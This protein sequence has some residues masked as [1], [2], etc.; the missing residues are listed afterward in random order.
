MAPQTLDARKNGST[1]AQVILYFVQ[2]N[3]LHWIDNNGN[4]AMNCRE[5]M[6][7]SNIN[8]RNVRFTV[9]VLRM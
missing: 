4:T 5:N 2:C 9:I 8:V 7:N 1:D 3:A 6:F